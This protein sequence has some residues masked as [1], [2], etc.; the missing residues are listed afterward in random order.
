MGVSWWH[1][2]DRFSVAA[3]P[4]EEFFRLFSA[5]R[6]RNKQASKQGSSCGSVSQVFFFFFSNRVFVFRPHFLSSVF[7]AL[8][9]SQCGSGSE[10]GEC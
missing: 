9:L 2:R 7:V 1:R 3:G 10:I 4:K 5:G 8:L 6:K